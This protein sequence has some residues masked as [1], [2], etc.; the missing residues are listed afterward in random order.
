L[1]VLKSITFAYDM[2]EDRMLAAINPGHPD[3]WSCWLTRRLTLA[4]LERAE[5]FL[6]NTS[7]LVQ[8]AS[9]DHRGEILAFEQDAAI[10]R[11]ANAITQTPAEV[12]Q[13][14]T[15][16]AELAKQLTISIQGNGFRIELQGEGG[17][18][19]AGLL[20]RDEFQRVLKMLQATAVGAGWLAT[21]TKSRTTSAAE[22]SNSTTSRH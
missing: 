10:A 16:S 14:S 12:L 11:T 8:R 20:A 5:E 7:P 3:A 15:A 18:S 21:P 1:P 2:K 22:E 6:A 4:L 17:G 13:S 19:A 9:A